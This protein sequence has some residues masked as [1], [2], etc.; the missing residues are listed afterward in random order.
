MVP[1]RGRCG[2]QHAYCKCAVPT[3]YETVSLWRSTQPPIA[4]PPIMP[5]LGC[6]TNHAVA[7]ARHLPAYLRPGRLAQRHTAGS[8]TRLQINHP[9]HSL[10][11]LTHSSIRSS[12]RSCILAATRLHE[13]PHLEPH[14][15]LELADVGQPV[16][17]VLVLRCKQAAKRVRE[18][19]RPWPRHR[20]P[21][22]PAPCWDTQSSRPAVMSHGSPCY[23]PG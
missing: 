22:P 7:R 12:I 11:K 15:V 20:S 5:S 4:A 19:G 21:L 9:F 17:Q 1:N 16:H 8:T 10:I 3:A 14:D 23:C 6:S 18:D 13:A 2:V